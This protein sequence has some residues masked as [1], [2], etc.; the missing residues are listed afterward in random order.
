MDLPRILSEHPRF[1]DALA[2]FA[3]APLVL[4]Y[5]PYA[6]RPLVFLP[7]ALFMLLLMDLSPRRALWRGYLFGLGQFGFGVSWIYQSIHHFGHA[8]AP[9]AALVTLGFVATVALFPALLAWSSRRLRVPA[10]ALGFVVMMPALWVLFEWIRG[11]FLTGFPWLLLGHTQVDTWL[12][13]AAPIM[14]VY[15]VSALVVLI[16]GLLAWALVAARMQR[17]WAVAAIAGVVAASALL[18]RLEWTELSGEPMRASLIQASIPQDR[19]WEPDQFIP[20]LELYRDL[21]RANWDSQLI[22]WPETAVPAYYREV[23]EGFLTPLAQE[24]QAHHAD[25]VLGV[26]KYDE[27]QR[28]VYNA[29]ISLSDPQNAYYKRHLVPFG[30]YL[31]VRGLLFWLA[32]FIEIPMSDLSRGAGRPLVQSAGQA[33]GISICYED[34]FGEEVIDA[35]PEAT[36]LVNVSNDAWFGRSRAP[37]Q[38]LEIARMRSRETERFMLRAT[39]TGI[40]AIIGHRGELISVSEQYKTQVVSASVQPR[41]GM[42]PYARWGNYPIVGVVLV[43]LFLSWAWRSRRR[44]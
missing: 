33:L 25:L 6:F 18:D 8:I 38:H 31:P 35:L 10:N 1:A 12:G 24:A 3:G 23:E 29:V 37:W 41:T 11:W 26:F 43:A 4:A 36:L 44:A 32:P 7:P 42:T 22:V 27:K 16:S 13:G 39:N 15:G 21:T 17:V 2:F 14:G 34:A 40:S 5:A 30:E 20:T 9:L 28:A 19:K